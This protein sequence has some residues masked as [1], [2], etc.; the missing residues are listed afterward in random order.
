MAPLSQVWGG[1]EGRFEGLHPS[2]N[3]LHKALRRR[4]EQCFKNPLFG[5]EDSDQIDC[6]DCVADL[7]YRDFIPRLP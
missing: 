7:D 3:D 5:F 6:L 4:G 1:G 2:T